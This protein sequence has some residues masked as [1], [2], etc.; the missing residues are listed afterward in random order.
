M[1]HHTKAAAAIDKRRA[2]RL[3]SY[4]RAFA[5]RVPLLHRQGSGA[6]SSTA[7]A[8]RKRTPLVS[9]ALGGMALLAGMLLLAPAA[10]AA[11]GAPTFG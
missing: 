8:G 5:T 6:S 9:A 3:R 2:S 1:K 4:L 11:P 10:L 7:A